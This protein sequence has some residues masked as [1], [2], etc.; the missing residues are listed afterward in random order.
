MLAGWK[1]SNYKDGVFAEFFHV[2]EAD[3]NLA[4]L[5]DDLDPGTACMLCDMMPTGFHAAELADIQFGE[6]VCVIGIGPV[7][8]MAVR[9][10]VLRGAGDVY[11]VGTRKDC[12][13]AAKQYGATDFLSYK[14]GDLAEQILERTRGKGVDKVVVAG[15]TADTFDA[16]I[17]MVKPGGIIANV[18]YLGAGDYVKL[19]RVEWGCGMAHKQIRGGLMPGGR[20]RAE[21][22]LRLI[23]TGRVDPGLLL[24]H[25]FYGFSH[26]E[27][28]L[29]LMKDK[30][31]GSDQARR[32]SCLE[33][34]RAEA[35][36]FCAGFTDALKIM[37]C[38]A[39]CAD[40]LIDLDDTLDFFKAGLV[41][42]VLVQNAA[43]LCQRAHAAL[44]QK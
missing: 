31:P 17:R 5:P 11:C 25:K 38:A 16:A 44:F 6:S 15:G 28:A 12:M 2:N 4:H 34:T 37:P 3:A 14:N 43:N 20:L 27:Q 9:A 10:C 39:V 21:R 1:F 24:T 30:T 7:G 18:N 33:K 22:L 41:R 26:V 23:E 42:R 13:D 36:S 40:C 32:L 29:Y 35:L 8:L 19:P